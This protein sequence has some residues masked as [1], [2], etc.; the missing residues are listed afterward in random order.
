MMSVD[1]AGTDD[2]VCT[3][4]DL[5]VF[6]RLD[7]V[8]NFCN[9]AILNQETGSGW[10]HVVVM[11]M[12]EERAIFEND[13]GGNHFCE[14]NEETSTWSGAPTIYMNSTSINNACKSV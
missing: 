10:C 14:C 2:L 4:N 8:P 12:N 1:E 13:A 7:V 9:L 3:V 5:G 11:V 6:R